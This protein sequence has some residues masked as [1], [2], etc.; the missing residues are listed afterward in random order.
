MSSSN[1]SV[2]LSPLHADGLKATKPLA[3]NEMIYQETPLYF[4][5]TVPNRQ[6]ALVCGNC[7]KF[8][9]SVGLQIKYLQKVYSREDLSKNKINENDESFPSYKHL[10]DIFPCQNHC[11]E[12]YCSEACRDHHVQRSHKLLCTGLIADSEADFNPLYQ[13]KIHALNTNEIFLMAADIYS[14][15]CQLCSTLNGASPS[16]QEI[17]NV[18]NQRFEGFV[19]NIWWEAIKPTNIKE[20]K[21]FKQTLQTLIKDCSSLLQDVFGLQELGL[22]SILNEEYLAR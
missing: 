12:L 6:H 8:L 7:S 20:K 9:G 4:L 1:V 3:V 11:G 22:D 19:R 14:E 17:A 2:F 15:L 18:F 21:T 13:F 16:N 10:S 5:Q